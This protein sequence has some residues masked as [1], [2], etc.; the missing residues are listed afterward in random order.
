MADLLKLDK[1]EARERAYPSQIGQQL[2]AF[3]SAFVE[4]SNLA[5]DKALAR[6]IDVLGRPNVKVAERVSLMDGT[7]LTLGMSMPAAM[8]TNLSPHGP[9]TGMIKGSL[10][11][12]ENN[13]ASEN[14]K[15]SQKWNING[16]AGLGLWHVDTSLTVE[17]SHSS[18]QSRETDYSSYV[19][20]E[21]NYGEYPEPEGVGIIKD[22][23]NTLSRAA[24]QVNLALAERK[25]QALQDDEQKL[26][27]VEPDKDELPADGP[28]AIEAEKDG[29]TG[30][31]SD[32]QGS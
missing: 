29:D 22:A 19:E 7:D 17:H 27:D 12:R 23:M 24:A 30:S 32:A 11:V 15:G 3:G 8:L 5:A 14:D 4:Q 21:T 20:W 6:T 13:K 28:T 31:G 25:I 26:K 9:K 16:G 1:T 18:D 2:G 10:R